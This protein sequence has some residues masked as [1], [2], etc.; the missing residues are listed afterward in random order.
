MK[1]NILT[2]TS[3]DDDGIPI[4]AIN[5]SNNQPIDISGFDEI[6]F[7][8]VDKK[9]RVLIQKKLSDSGIVFETGGATSVDFTV[10]EPATPAIG[11]TYLNIT[12]GVS[13]ITAQAVIA[14]YLYEWNGV[15]WTE[16]KLGSN[17]LGRIL[18]Q[19]Q[20][21]Y[22][23]SGAYKYDLQFTDAITNEDTTPADSFFIVTKDKTQ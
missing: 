9:G 15:D 22:N 17:G 21:T 8:V 23:L 4:V 7:T 10:A 19:K 6:I 20:D 2:V 14:N 1:L 12:T 13:S 3:G 11:D 5:P 16:I 18:L